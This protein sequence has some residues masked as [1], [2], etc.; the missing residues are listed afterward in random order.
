MDLQCFLE[1]GDSIVHF[2]DTERYAASP[3]HAARMANVRGIMN[4]FSSRKWDTQLFGDF[5]IVDTFAYMCK[6][7][8]SNQLCLSVVFEKKPQLRISF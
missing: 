3:L 2:V 4:R 1:M 7:R 8:L 5:H 6:V